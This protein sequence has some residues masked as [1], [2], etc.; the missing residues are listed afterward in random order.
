MRGRLELHDGRLR[1]MVSRHDAVLDDGRA[2]PATPPHPENTPVDRGARAGAPRA[3]RGALRDR[4]RGPW[5]LGAVPDP[6]DSAARARGVA[7]LG[8]PRA[9]GLTSGAC[10]DAVAAQRGVGALAVPHPV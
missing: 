2:V 7:A 3:R 9:D 8:A 10:L 6:K 5:C 4:S 1:T